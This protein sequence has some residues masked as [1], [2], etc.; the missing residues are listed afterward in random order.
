MPL[1][2]RTGPAGTSAF[3][4]ATDKK[5]HN[6]MRIIPALHCF[7]NIAESPFEA[8]AN[9]ADATPMTSSETTQIGPL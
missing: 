8:D 7:E 1:A 5:G 9:D 6:L 2:S 4:G 3:F